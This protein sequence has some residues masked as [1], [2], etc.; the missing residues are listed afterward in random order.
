MAMHFHQNAKEP[1]NKFSNFHNLE[2]NYIIIDGNAYNTTE[3]AFQSNH[4]IHVSDRK[5]FEVGGKFDSWYGMN[6][7]FKEE[8]VEKK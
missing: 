1:N 2:N 6:I 7:L 8:D 4:K 3:S 5:H